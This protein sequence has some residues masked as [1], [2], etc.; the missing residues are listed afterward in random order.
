MG[1]GRQGEKE[2]SVREENRD[3]DIEEGDR[4]NCYMILYTVGNE[5]SDFISL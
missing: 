1:K 5:V 4:G 3:R 2:I